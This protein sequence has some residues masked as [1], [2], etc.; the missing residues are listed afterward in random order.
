MKFFMGNHLRM[1][2][3]GCSDH[4]DIHIIKG[5][6]GTNLIVE[7]RSVYLLILMAKGIEIV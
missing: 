3:L 1:T 7:V 4:C 2:I 5:L 6:W